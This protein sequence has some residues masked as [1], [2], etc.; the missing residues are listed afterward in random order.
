MF[1]WRN[2]IRWMLKWKRPIK[3]QL[4]A[5]QS[6]QRFLPTWQSCRY[7][8]EQYVWLLL[9][10]NCV[11]RLDAL[12]K[13]WWLLI[14]LSF[15]FIWHFDADWNAGSSYCCSLV[16]FMWRKTLPYMNK[17]KIYLVSSVHH[18]YGQQAGLAPPLTQSKGRRLC[19]YKQWELSNPWSPTKPLCMFL[20]MSDDDLTT[21]ISAA[22]SILFMASFAVIFLCVRPFLL[23]PLSKLCWKGCSSIWGSLN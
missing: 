6:F 13:L 23:C 21:L 8:C 2:T 19:K 5:W 4:V 20:M 17:W 10:Y 14:W 15:L 18:S 3:P 7:L 22:C 11:C 16:M 9:R 12:I 1:P